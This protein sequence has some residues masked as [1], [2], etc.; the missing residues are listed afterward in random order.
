[1]DKAVEDLR[2]IT[3]NLVKNSIFSFQIY[4]SSQRENRIFKPV[5]MLNF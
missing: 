5:K 3:G 4:R 2:N 1:M